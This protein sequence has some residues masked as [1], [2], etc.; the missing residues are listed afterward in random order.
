VTHAASAFLLLLAA[1][2]CAQ[3]PADQPIV[4]IGPK[5]RAA[6]LALPTNHGGKIVIDVTRVLNPRQYPADL[7]VRLAVNDRPLARF[8]LYPPDQPARI[9][10]R[11]PKAAVSVIV[12]LEGSVQR[13]PTLIELR[14]VAF[15]NRS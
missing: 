10:V 5:A 7:T 8:A 12:R 14:A 11:V 3:P 1:L 15:P 13:S 6:V 2:A 4:A 9:A